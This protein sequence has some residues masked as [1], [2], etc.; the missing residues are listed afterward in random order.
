M[1][2]RK[3]KIKQVEMTPLEIDIEAPVDDAMLLK[4]DHTHGGKSYPAGTP[5]DELGVSDTTLR[6]LKERN[7][8]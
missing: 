2:L 1:S 8:V 3:K 6:F 5:I 4:V 7:I